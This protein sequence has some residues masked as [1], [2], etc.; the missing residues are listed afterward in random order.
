MKAVHQKLS[1]LRGEGTSGASARRMQSISSFVRFVAHEHSFDC[2]NDDVDS[3]F[4]FDT[5]NVVEQ[6]RTVG[7]NHQSG[8]RRSRVIDLRGD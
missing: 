3:L 4:D 6:I 2:D 1:T 8:E 5:L 7:A